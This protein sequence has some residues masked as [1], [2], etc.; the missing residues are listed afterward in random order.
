MR[1]SDTGS[2]RTVGLSFD[3]AAY[4]TVNTIIYFHLGWGRVLWGWVS[5]FGVMPVS[6]GT[7][8]Q[9]RVGCPFY[10]KVVVCGHCLMTLSLTINETLKWLS[11]LLILMQES[12]WW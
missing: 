1:E 4:R 3:I 6:R 10:S 12:F 9:I 11:S 2:D 7:S 5:R 8:V